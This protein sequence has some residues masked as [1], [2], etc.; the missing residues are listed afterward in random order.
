MGFNSRSQHRFD[1]IGP[2]GP[3]L[4]E[5]SL[6]LWNFDF[7]DNHLVCCTARGF[8]KQML[9]K[10]H[11]SSSCAWNTKISH[12]KV[13]YWIFYWISGCLKWILNVLIFSFFLKKK[14]KWKKSVGNLRLL[15]AMLPFAQTLEG[16]YTVPI[17]HSHKINMV[18]AILRSSKYTE[19]IKSP[20]LP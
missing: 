10:G 2:Y 16:W 5:F 6:P 13:E 14:W 4:C 1:F 20:R 8:W 17:R 18:M 12:L 11:G 7:N 3:K 9:Y 15:S 19:T